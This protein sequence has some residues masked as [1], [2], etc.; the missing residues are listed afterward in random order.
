MVLPEGSLYRSVSSTFYR[1]ERDDETV[2]VNDGKTT[3]DSGGFMSVLLI[4]K[5]KPIHRKNFQ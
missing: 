4:R 2:C 5:S 3:F 1:K